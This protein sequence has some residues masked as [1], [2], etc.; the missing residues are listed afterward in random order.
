M[1]PENS[2]L[3]LECRCR[4]AVSCREVELAAP[5]FRGQPVAE[6]RLCPQIINILL[7]LYLWQ[8]ARSRHRAFWTL[9][10]NDAIEKAGIG[11]RTENEEVKL[12]A[13]QQVRQ[14]L[15]CGC[16]AEI[17][18]DLLLLRPGWNGDLRPGSLV[19]GKKNFREAS[20]VGADRKQSRLK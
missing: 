11:R 15:R 2:E 12:R 19:H 16:R 1:N 3:N 9:T 20:L 6:V 13:I 8:R 17:G 10:Q 5:D 7:S 4:W 18:Y 14:N